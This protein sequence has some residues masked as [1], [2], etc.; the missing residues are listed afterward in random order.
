MVNFLYLPTSL[1]VLYVNSI[2]LGWAV[3]LSRLKHQEE[4]EDVVVSN[5]DQI[6]LN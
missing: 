1:R 4:L 5:L 2:D 3:V 6:E